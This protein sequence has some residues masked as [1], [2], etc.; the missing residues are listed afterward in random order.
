LIHYGADGASALAETEK[1]TALINFASY[2]AEA[3]ALLDAGADIDATNSSGN[4]P[5]MFA[6][7]PVPKRSD[8][9]LVRYLVRRGANV[10]LKNRIGEDA[11]AAARRHENFEAADFLR[12][13]KAA[14]GTY[15]KYLRT[16]R[17]ELVRLRSLCDRGRA[18]PPSPSSAKLRT[19][20]AETVVLQRLFGAPLKGRL[21]N[22]IFWHIFKYWRTRR[23]G[24]Y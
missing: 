11:E 21:P 13:V 22:E 14:G 9:A 15:T 3:A 10:S 5:L 17:I 6:T 18:A 19:I 7:C 4:T 2:P 8:D 16:P 23:D 24:Y 1:S 12:D 20:S